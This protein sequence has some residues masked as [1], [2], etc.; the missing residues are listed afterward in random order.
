MF[1]FVSINMFKFDHADLIDVHKNIFCHG[2][3]T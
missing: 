1:Y 3:D 2:F